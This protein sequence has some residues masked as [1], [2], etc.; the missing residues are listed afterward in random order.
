M[1]GA[2]VATTRIRHHDE[3]LKDG[4]EIKDATEEEKA[5]LLA[6]GFAQRKDLT[7]S[8]MVEA[9]VTAVDKTRTRTRRQQYERKDLKAEESQSE[10]E[11]S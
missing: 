6:M 3:W 10:E 5:D 1:T 9:L 8:G 11:E 4:D 2:I 7:L